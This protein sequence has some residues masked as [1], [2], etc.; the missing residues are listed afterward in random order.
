MSYCVH[1]GVKLADSE[2]GRCPLCGIVNR[3]PLSPAD[4]KASPAYPCRTEEQNLQR[5]KG[6]IF[7]L[8]SLLFVFPAVLCLLV[9]LVTAHRLTWSIYP[10]AALGLMWCSCGITLTLN[11]YRLYLSYLFNTLAMLVY[12]FMTERLNRGTW[13]LPVAL[14]VTCY[15]SLCTAGITVIVRRRHITSRVGISGVILILAGIACVLTEILL[16]LT[17][18]GAPRFHWSPYALAPCLFVGIVLIVFSRNAAVMNE[19]RRR[20]HF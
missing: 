17:F 8:F 5:S 1:C 7:R 19:L 12:M 2:N 9:D 18:G 10:A 11:K 15:L 20:L 14:P 4:E 6:Y 3:D 16:S 13:F